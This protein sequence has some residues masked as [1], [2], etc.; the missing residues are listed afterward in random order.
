MFIA[1]NPRRP[2]DSFRRLAP[3]PL[4][5][6]PPI[7]RTLFQVP[8]PASPLFA[9]LTKT[10]GCVPKIPIS[11]HPDLFAQ[12]SLSPHH[13]PQ[14]S[15]LPSTPH[16]PLTSSSLTPLTATPMNLLACL[17]N[18]RLTPQLNPLAATLTKNRG[19]PFPAV[20][21]AANLRIRSVRNIQHYG[22]SNV[23]P[24]SHFPAPF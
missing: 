19:A 5:P 11:V 14:S 17:A 22:R 3:T 4:S 2:V 9:T 12:R 23:Y 7:L 6:L 10:A 24:K 13:P 21:I 20:L 8:Y 16:R 15:F 18:K 1:L